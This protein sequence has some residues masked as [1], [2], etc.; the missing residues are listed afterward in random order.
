[1]FMQDNTYIYW[2]H[3]DAM[4]TNAGR[5]LYKNIY[6]SLYCKG[7]KRVTQGL[8][9]KGSWRSNITAI[10]WP[11][12][13]WPSRC[14]FLVLLILNRRPW[15]QLFWVLAF[16]TASYQHL[17]WTPTHQG[18]NGPFGLVWFSL[19]HLVYNWLQL[20]LNSTGRRTQLATDWNR[21][22]TE[23]YN[24]S[25]PTRSLKSNV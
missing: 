18:P 3:T 20:Q 17:L 4:I 21:N 1:M 6:L 14:V 7:S 22:S 11:P 19:P 23:L 9:V 25:T 15:D 24:R 13:L 12:N 8:R 16:F 2:I 10:F 5:L